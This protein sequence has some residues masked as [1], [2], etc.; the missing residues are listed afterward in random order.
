MPSIEAGGPEVVAISVTV[1]VGMGGF[2]AFGS[3]GME[4]GRIGVANGSGLANAVKRSAMV[5]VSGGE[6]LRSG[7]EVPLN[8]SATLAESKVG[9]ILATFFNV[10]NLKLLVSLVSKASPAIS[11]AIFLIGSVGV[12]AANAQVGNLESVQG[13]VS[14]QHVFASY[15]SYRV[16]Y[17][18]LSML[19]EILIERST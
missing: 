18:R 12:S 9:R 8:G 19:S 4:N 14:E 17:P 15:C 2:P 11:M 3:I 10:L 16:C 13:T 1:A 6:G 5:L 7:V